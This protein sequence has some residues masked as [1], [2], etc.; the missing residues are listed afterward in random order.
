MVSLK[1]GQS[2]PTARPKA[3]YALQ[4]SLLSFQDSHTR[5]PSCP[6]MPSRCW[7][8]LAGLV[9]IPVGDPPDPATTAAFN[10]HPRPHRFPEPHLFHTAPAPPPT[11]QTL[12]LHGQSREWPAHS[13][14]RFFSCCLA[15]LN[16]PFFISSSGSNTCGQRAAGAQHASIPRSM[17]R[18]LQGATTSAAKRRLPAP[19]VAAGARARCATPTAA[20]AGAG[21]AATA[22]AA[23]AASRG[24]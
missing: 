3:L 4:R 22:A 5:D 10:A 17:L 8:Q 19:A 12:A 6:V 13:F 1:K 24:P 7:S 21:T 15:L 23:A 16:L 11:S 18:N 20:V 14:C 9:T 2:P